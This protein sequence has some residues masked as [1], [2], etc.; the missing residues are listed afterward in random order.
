MSLLSLAGME[1]LWGSEEVCIAFGCSSMFGNCR[2]LK[3]L[4]PVPAYIRPVNYTKITIQMQT[5]SRSGAA[6]AI[7]SGVTAEY[8]SLFIDALQAL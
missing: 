1:F 8:S 4:Y 2:A 3:W 5:P 6:N 7:I